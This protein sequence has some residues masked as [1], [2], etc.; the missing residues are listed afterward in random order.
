MQ[1][2][3]SKVAML[4]GR[5]AE[6]CGRGSRQEKNRMKMKKLLTE[7]SHMSLFVTLGDKEVQIFNL[8]TEI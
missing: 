5:E 1:I 6:L 2:P 7:M 4:R 3:C 8:G